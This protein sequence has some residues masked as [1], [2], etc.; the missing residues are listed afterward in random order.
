MFRYTLLSFCFFLLGCTYT[1]SYEHFLRLETGDIVES[2][3]DRMYI[4]FDEDVYLRS[5]RQVIPYEIS[6]EREFGLRDCGINR[7]D[8]SVEDQYCILDINEMDLLGF[9][10][11]N[12]PFVLEYQ[13]PRE[14]CEYASFYAPWHF[15]QLSGFGPPNLY[16][17]TVEQNNNPVVLSTGIP[18]GTGTPLGTGNNNESR[19]YYATSIKSPNTNDQYPCGIVADW[20]R[21]D[22]EEEN[23]ISKQFCKNSSSNIVYDL[24]DETDY[25]S[26]CCF[27]NYELTSYT[28]NEDGI[29]VPTVTEED[30]GGTLRECIGG[31]VRLNWE[32]NVSY[33]GLGEYPVPQIF[34]T[35]ERGLREQF[36]IEKPII[37]SG[38]PRST[39]NMAFHLQYT[40]VGIANYYEGIE[41]LQ[42]DADGGCAECPEVFKSDVDS[43]VGTLVGYPYYTLECLD[44]N[45]EAIHRV[46]FIV[47]EWNTLEEFHEFQDSAGDNGD[48]NVTGEEGNDC[49][50]YDADEFENRCN[51]LL[52]LDDL[53]I[54][55]FL[56]DIFGRLS[57][58]PQV[59]YSKSGGG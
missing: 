42:W 35:W 12:I 49:N 22:D 17:C 38:D 41:D 6:T 33:D 13:I 46:H 28:Q 44:S 16:K 5:G 50:Y 10:G 30:W 7:D 2:E 11:D 54:N 40:S 18:L 56:E 58:Y 57:G 31:P 36:E 37:W 14:T 34:N 15:N 25:L 24:S 45:M 9:E 47:R 32:T 39:G 4:R 51:D 52:D 8:S 21:E 23:W 1:S 48:P 29:V 43:S 3:E 20:I 19:V 26:N 59:D 53:T 27:G 55:N